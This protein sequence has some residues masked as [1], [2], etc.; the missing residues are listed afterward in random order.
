[1]K[2]I[3]VALRDELPSP[4]LDS[5]EYRV[6]YTGVGKVNAS[7]SAVLACTSSPCDLV[8]N[9]GTAGAFDS[10]LSGR[11]LRIGRVRQRDMDARPLFP[12]GVTPFS[13]SASPDIELCDSDVVLSSGDN[14]VTSPP[15]LT[16]DC[17]DM[18]AYAIAHICRHFG[19]R[20]CCYKYITDLANDDS[21]SDWQQNC[22]S[23]SSLFLDLL[24]SGLD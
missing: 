15:E 2:H 11:L 7:L 12:L 23:G 17:V 24:T 18:E 21:A 20:F 14:F 19:K 8:I 16:S 5:S 22:S 6:W 9:Y 1:M 13:D 4:D 3:L 10:S